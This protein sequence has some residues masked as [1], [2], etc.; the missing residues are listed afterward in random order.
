MIDATEVTPDSFDTAAFIAA[1][2]Q[3]D[4]IDALALK[5]GA[6]ALQIMGWH[7]QAAEVWQACLDD[8]IGSGFHEASLNRGVC[9]A[10]RGGNRARAGDARAADDLLEA[11][12]CFREALDLKSDYPQ[13]RTNLR[14]VNDDLFRLSGTR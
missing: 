10:V 9:L 7:S 14:Q 2:R 1:C 4:P 6:G 3:A 5:A 8:P 13:A 11:R 12:R